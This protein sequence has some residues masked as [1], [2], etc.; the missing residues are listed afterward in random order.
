ML[1]PRYKNLSQS[2]KMKS[3][4]IHGSNL[5]RHEEDRTALDPYVQI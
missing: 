5:I 3:I 1:D 4:K 2:T